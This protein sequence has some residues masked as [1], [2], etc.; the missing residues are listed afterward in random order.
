MKNHLAL[1]I[2]TVVITLSISNCASPSSGTDSIS[3]GNLPAKA[4][5]HDPDT[6]FL[7]KTTSVSRSASSGGFSL[8]EVQNNGSV[9]E[10]SFLDEEGNEVQV[11]VSNL[12][13]F[14]SNYIGMIF[15]YQYTVYSVVIDVSDGTIY[16]LS[17]YSLGT[18]FYRN[19]Y[20]YITGKFN[21]TLYKA[22]FINKI[23]VPI[24][25]PDYDPISRDAFIYVTTDNLICVSGKMFYPDNRAPL[26][27]N[28]LNFNCAA[29]PMSRWRSTFLTAGEVIWEVHHTTNA[30]DN[31]YQN[32]FVDESGVRIGTPTNYGVSTAGS[33]LWAI[34]VNPSIRDTTRY[35][36]YENG[37]FKIQISGDNLSITYTDKSFPESIQR[38]PVTSGARGYL[39]GTKLFICEGNEIKYM[40][41]VTDNDF[42]T[43]VS[44]T[45]IIKWNVLYDDCITYSSYVTAT[46]IATYK[47]TI[48]GS[49]ELLSNSDMEIEQILEL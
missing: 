44:P 49:S 27:T 37:Y 22:D 15:S 16:N 11:S 2:F 28:S 36:L 9:R 14:G 18:A 4:D 38:Y 31:S 7:G 10:V 47:I 42:T 45:S 32:I 8:F 34:W 30:S 26:D 23:A 20:L 40:D 21:S 33:L 41:I 43:L 12:Y 48:G 39:S 13:N 1:L 25:N 6:I 46:K 35:I 29:S 17:D 19:N 5:F 3:G 24:N